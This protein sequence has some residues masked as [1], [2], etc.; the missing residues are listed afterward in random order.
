MHQ[1]LQTVASRALYGLTQPVLSAGLSVGW[2]RR[3]ILLV[4]TFVGSGRNLDELLVD[5]DVGGVADAKCL[6]ELV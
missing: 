2:V 1:Y 6:L 5:A 4:R 3:G